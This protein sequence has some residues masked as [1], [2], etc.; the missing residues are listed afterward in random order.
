M[1][2]IR[3]NIISALVTK[4]STIT[5]G[6]GYQQNV[7]SVLDYPTHF[8]NIDT[9]NYPVISIYMGNSA[10]NYNLGASSDSAFA[11][12]LRCYI[13]GGDEDS[14]RESA[15][16]IIEDIDKC[17]YNNITLGDSNVI[18][19]ELTSIEPPF[20]WLELGHTGIVDLQV[21]VLYRRNY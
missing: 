20:L 16:K 19:A 5:T 17:L 7:G 3:E 8:E 12:G 9:A 1:S 11:I 13:E 6:N 14:I 4:L 10:I 15:N 21:S 2:N 18:K